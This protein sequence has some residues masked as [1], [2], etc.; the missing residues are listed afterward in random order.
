M[1]FLD[2]TH[3]AD[4]RLWLIGVT[5]NHGGMVRAQA[6]VA[7]AGIT[8][9][10]PW[11]FDDDEEKIAQIVLPDLLLNGINTVCSY[12]V[13]LRGIAWQDRYN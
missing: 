13:V 9:K 5:V 4:R 2:S 3:T 6:L 12:D 8:E 10:K 1:R 7:S 11:L